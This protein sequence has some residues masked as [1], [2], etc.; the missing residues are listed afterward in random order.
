M[1]N[2]TLFLAGLLL[3]G[4]AHA[5][6][7]DLPLPQLNHKSWILG[8]GVPLAIM[9]ITQTTDGT[10]W[11]ASQYGLT[12][13]DGV[14]FVRYDGPAGQPL[15]STNIRTVAASVDGGLWIGFTFGGISFL[16]NGTL[17]HYGEREGL[18]VAS[19][20]DIVT[21]K[22]GVTYA[23]TTQ[24]LY[25][26]RG[27]KWERIVI[28]SGNPT[29]RVSTATVDREG[30]LWAAT[31]DGL[32]ARPITVS[33]FREVAKR[34]TDGS[35]NRVAFASGPHGELWVTNL[36]REGQLV[37]VDP[38]TDAGP[39]SVHEFPGDDEV[40]FDR[41][42]NLWLGGH[43]VRRLAAAK[44]I[45]DLD[46]LAR[47][48][49]A[50]DAADGPTGA[51]TCFFEDREG[52][53]WVGNTR[54]LD[55]FSP[56]NVL[57]VPDHASDTGLVNGA[58]VAGEAGAMWV[59]DINLNADGAYS[60]LEVSDNRVVDRYPAPSQLTSAYRSPDGAIWFGGPSG[61]A[62]L[63]H[64]RLLNATALP[65]K[66]QVQAMV[67]DR[68]GA[69]WVSIVRRGVFRF[70]GQ[71]SLNG[72][73]TALPHSP[74][75]VEVA[76]SQGALW[77]G[78]PDG[79]LAR[80][81]GSTVTLFGTQDGLTVG[82][83]TAIAARGPHLWIA[84][85]RGLLRFDGSHFASVLTDSDAT[86]TGVSGIVELKNGDVWLNGNTG[87]A[88]ITGSELK[89]AAHDSSYRVHCE[90]F[91][92]LDGL[93]GYAVQV[94][95]TPSAIE[96][97]DGRLWFGLQSGLVS[98]DP[99]RIKHNKLPPPVSIWSINGRDIQDAAVQQRQLPAH[100]TNVRIEY[101]AASLTI[102][103]RVRF[104]YKIEG[105]DQDWQDAGDRREAIYTNLGP[106]RYT[107]RVIAANNDGVWNNIGASLLFTIAPAF[108]QTT[109]FYALGVVLSL[110]CLWILYQIRIRQVSAQVRGRLEER[111]AERERIARELHDTLLQS[112]Q[113]LI[114]R[115][116]AGI[117]LK[118]SAD[119]MEKAL[120][121]ADE[122]LAE[123][124]DRVKY[125]RSSSSTDQDLFDALA[126]LG[127]ELATEQ[128]A[129]FRATV[130]GIP[131]DLHPI[132]REEAMFIAREALTNAFRHASA[133]QIEAEVIFEEAALRVTVRDDG[134][135][136]ADGVIETG[137]PEHWGLMGMRE[138][139]AKIR[140]TVTI[141]SKPNAGTEMDLR[142]P[143]R[144]AYRSYERGRLR[145]WWRRSSFNPQGK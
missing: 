28:D 80:L 26:Q 143:A 119:V 83:V 57:E 71:W 99:S 46:D 115:L 128:T 40:F 113:G 127:N 72:N 44:L 118:Q 95:P 106:G 138:R 107:F 18:P 77:F 29:A 93:P 81:D 20:N 109:W 60:I 62:R 10:L 92:Q 15:A 133:Q 117:K 39:S 24:G 65:Y 36:Q 88:H 43:S 14:R 82:T 78:Y 114:L 101:T 49:E 134:T 34:G 120:E 89:R 30:T 35:Q 9:N 90:V 11:I 131:R 96:G 13:F 47:R 145:T 75:V 1:K 38:L 125:L 53:V 137:R 27:S 97:S 2:T 12:R 142:V 121:R 25:Q 17:L 42:G 67:Q 108:Y 130:I 76:D 31:D 22:M 3:C 141:W 55:R 8:S 70:D 116:R 21:D 59:G 63:E 50:F 68:T 16:K 79:R 87:V 85:E 123:G 110:V 100:T 51:A 105:L 48:T 33:N 129:Q 41:E 19:V 84:G 58:V 23:G 135:G 6:A 73:L 94:R 74:A 32:W 61:I 140:A 54:G 56:S 7:P 112:V 5:A 124:R 91:D 64:G 4:Q 111:I 132:V 103:E 139:A 126:S 66:A 52:N 104:R 122:V 37:R 102:P 136:I 144:I 86:I 45:N 69:M 98:I